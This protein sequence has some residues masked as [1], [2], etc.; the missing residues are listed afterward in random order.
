MMVRMRIVMPV[1][2]STYY[3]YQ[4]AALTPTDGQI[5]RTLLVVCYMRTPVK[6]FLIGMTTVTKSQQAASS[7][8][9][10]ILYYLA[11]NDHRRLIKHGQAHTH[12]DVTSTIMN[13]TQSG[14]HSKRTIPR[15]ALAPVSDTNILSAVKISGNDTALDR[16]MMQQSYGEF[17]RG[18]TPCIQITINADSARNL[19]P[20]PRVLRSQPLTANAR[21]LSPSDKPALHRQRDHS[22]CRRPDTPLRVRK[23]R[24]NLKKD[25]RIGEVPPPC[26]GCTGSENSPRR[27]HATTPYD[28]LLTLS[29]PGSHAPSSLRS[30]SLEPFTPH[31]IPDNIAPEQPNITHHRSVSK[32]MLSSLKSAAT[33]TRSTHVIRPMESEASLLRRISGRRKPTDKSQPER[34]AYS[35]D[36]S[37]DSVASEPDHQDGQSTNRSIHRLDQR[38]CTESTVS[39]SALVEDLESVTPPLGAPSGDRVL[40]KHRYSGAPESPPPRNPVGFELTPRPFDKMMQLPTQQTTLQLLMPCIQLHVTMDTSVVDYSEKRTIWIAIEAI[41]KTHVVDVPIGG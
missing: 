16:I 10:Y 26:V 28:G 6:P 39:T 4:T 27:L 31:T 17:K 15:A 19:P 21:P 33:R 9:F 13:P 25:E 20:T 7:C 34:R 37:R 41:V 22:A 24:E 32:R 3:V 1:S 29:P 40:F 18:S 38:S 12:V 5:H 11:C 14:Y 36:V 2:R 23:T 8:C 35:F 30:I